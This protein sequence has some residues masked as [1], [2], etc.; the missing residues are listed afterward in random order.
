MEILSAPHIGEGAFGD[1]T[2]SFAD[3]AET[4]TKE[5]GLIVSG[6]CG[7]VH[8]DTFGY[9]YTADN[10]VSYKLYEDGTMLI[11]GNGAMGDFYSEEF[12]EVNE[13]RMIPWY[14]HRGDIKK[15]V[16][17]NGVTSIGENAFRDC[18]SLGSIR[19]PD[20][21]L[22]IGDN[23][24]YECKGLKSI[25]IPDSVADMGI[26]AFEG[27]SNLKSVVLPEKNDGLRSIILKKQLFRN[28]TSLKKINLPS[29]VWKIEEKAFEGCT[30]LTRLTL[31]EKLDSIGSYAFKGCSGL[32]SVKDKSCYISKIDEGAFKDCENLTSVKISEVVY[33]GSY[34]FKGCKNLT[35]VKIL[36]A[37]DIR[38]YA[39]EDCVS[40]KKI[41]L[42]EEVHLSCGVF[43]GC[44]SLEE[45]DIPEI[46]YEDNN[47][48]AELYGGLFYNCKNLKKVTVRMKSLVAIDNRV[49]YG[50]KKLESITLYSYEPPYIS[51]HGFDG[52]PK[53][54]TIYVPKGSVSIYKEW[55]RKEGI[56]LNKIN[57]K[58]M[59]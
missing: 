13:K 7:K 57:I 18:V 54:V 35:A 14:D 46:Y 59:K 26:S 5:S 48:Y 44:T 37:S 52:L 58:A 28:C 51:E 4:E 12:F 38:A 42:P 8:F 17:E 9:F 16:V 53:V 15:V 34:V 33:L 3:A 1:C 39:F 56:N 31:P 45:A 55:F 49:F 29:K 25:V 20:S 10:N 27:C 30:S 36:R 2:V 40:L 24:F 6:A 47:T 22:T 23:A 32:R 19:L 43:K 21:I 11:Y 41:R 50:C